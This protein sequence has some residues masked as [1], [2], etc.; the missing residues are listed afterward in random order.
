M[1]EWWV[2]FRSGGGMRLTQR[3]YEIFTAVLELEQWQFELPG[4]TLVPKN[5]MLLDKKLSCPYY[6]RRVRQ[7]YYLHMFGDREAMV[8]TLYGDIE[9]FLLNLSRQESTGQ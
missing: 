2:N 9:K 6:L 8:A 4:Q 7:Q 3:G 5:L 1:R